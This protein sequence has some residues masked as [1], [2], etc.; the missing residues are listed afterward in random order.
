MEHI[1]AWAGMAATLVGFA[2]AA[3]KKLAGIEATLQVIAECIKTVPEDHA[4]LKAL[5]PR[6]DRLENRMD[7]L[8][9]Q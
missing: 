5:V 9:S 4:T 3:L 1:T 6:V 2:Y 7:T 8:V